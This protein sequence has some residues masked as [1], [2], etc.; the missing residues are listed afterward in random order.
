MI[1]VPI[2]L[3]QRRISKIVKGG[4]D[5]PKRAHLVIFRQCSSWAGPALWA[6]GRADN[7][8]G[9]GWNWALDGP[10]LEF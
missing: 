2:S 4:G 8:C 10:G 1:V 7:G 6:M 9:L 3:T 5:N